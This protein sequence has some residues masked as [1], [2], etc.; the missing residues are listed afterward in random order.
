MAEPITIAVDA[1]GGDA[2]AQVCVPASI[3]FVRRHPGV[4]IILVGQRETLE[5]LVAAG[6]LPAGVGIHDARQV[7]AMDEPPADA[8]RKKKDSS[9]RVAV[10]LVKEGAANACV[11]AGNTGA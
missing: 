6:G 7:V 3:E 1:M 8:L 4:R 9:M 2:G 10:D 11:S 5:P